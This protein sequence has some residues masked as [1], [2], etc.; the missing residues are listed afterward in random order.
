MPTFRVAGRT[1]VYIGEAWQAALA[2]GC[3]SVVLGVVMMVWPGRSVSMSELLFGVAML[4]TAAW[5]M[6]LAFRGRIRTGL[7]ILEFGTALVS[8]LLAMWCMRSGDW[9]SLVALW[10]GL[11]WVI[12]GVVQA[13]VAVWSDQLPGA[14]RQEIAGL[15]TLVAGLAVVIW[16]IDTL[17]ALA[18]LAGVCLI[19]LGISEIRIAT[20]IARPE[21]TPEHV[22]VQGLLRSHS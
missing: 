13:T 22:G 12:R 6:V 10:V 17:D 1:D 14:G 7:K 11:G 8:V 19:L 4:L 20:R 5:Q 15:L 2:I 21:S 18:V 16:P 3:T 9:V